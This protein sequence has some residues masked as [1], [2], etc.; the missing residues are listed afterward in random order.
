MDRKKFSK[1]YPKLSKEMEEKKGVV[2]IQ[3]VRVTPEKEGK[4]DS[5]PSGTKEVSSDYAPG[6]IFSGTFRGQ[7]TS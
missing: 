5:K 6:R 4:R 7:S 1:K 3:G 2:P